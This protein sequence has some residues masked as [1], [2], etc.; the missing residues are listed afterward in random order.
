LRF[1]GPAAVAIGSTRQKGLVAQ[2][3]RAGG[4]K[5]YYCFEKGCLHR[6]KLSTEPPAPRVHKCQTHRGTGQDCPGVLNRD[7]Y[8]SSDFCPPYN[9]G[10]LYAVSPGTDAAVPQPVASREHSTTHRNYWKS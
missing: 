10:E 7:E 5:R 1:R 4:H 6:S 2:S 9:A 3:L 8:G